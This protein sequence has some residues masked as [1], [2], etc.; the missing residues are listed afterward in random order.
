M[1]TSLKTLVLILTSV[2]VTALVRCLERQLQ[3]TRLL[4]RTMMAESPARPIR[5]LSNDCIVWRDHSGRT[6]WL[7]RI[8]GSDGAA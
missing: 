3:G 5:G 4:Y 7:K 6:D 8:V 2:V 1:L